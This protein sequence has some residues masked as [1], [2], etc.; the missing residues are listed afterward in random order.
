MISIYTDNSSNLWVPSESCSNCGAH[1]RYNHN[2]STTYIA[3]GT[4]KN[5][6]GTGQLKGFLSQI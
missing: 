1:N 4:G 5:K 6:Y 3:N 2:D